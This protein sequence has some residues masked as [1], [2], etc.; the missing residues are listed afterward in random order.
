MR[1]RRALP[2][3]IV[4]VLMLTY[5]TSNYLFVEDLVK[6]DLGYISDEVWYVSAS[7]NML[8]EFWG[9]KPNAE[10]EGKTYATVVVWLPQYYNET[11]RWLVEVAGLQA[12][13]KDD[14]ASGS[15]RDGWDGGFAVLASKEILEE[16]ASNPNVEVYFGYP[17]PDHPGIIN[18]LNFEHPPLAK[19]VIAGV[20]LLS[21]NPIAWKIPSLILG[22]AII[23][24][25]YLV[26]RK[27]FGAIEGIIASVFIF[28]EQTVKAMSMVAMLD[29][30]LA[31]LTLL[32]LYLAVRFKNVWPS[33]LTVGL[34]AS[35]KMSGA[36]AIPALL[37]LSVKKGFLKRLP[38]IILAPIA[39]Y[40]LA[41]T[42]VILYFGGVW[43]WINNVRSAVG[44]YTTPRPSGPPTAT[45]IEFLFGGAS[46]PL[47]FNPPLSASPNIALTLLVIPLTVLL[48]PLAIKGVLKGAGAI[49]AWFWSTYF[50]YV[51]VYLAGNTTL[52]AF[53]AVQFMPIAAIIGSS[54]VTFILRHELLIKALRAYVEPFRRKPRLEAEFQP[55]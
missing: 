47:S 34:A 5:F 11:Y 33:T 14:Y 2:F 32:A 30:Y 46:F 52:Y 1:W 7:R 16:A 13:V 26:A 24:L 38:A 45:P 21:D 55:S 43:K 23:L 4:A 8:R 22:S 27:V 9:L 31:F 40:T 29:I 20:M 50:G 48:L 17:Y 25:A 35:A 36:F 3:A 37:A 44:W 28:T 51:A 53:Y 49:L 6:Q 15:L 41:S 12:I 18:Y 54:I 10:V 19:Y 39:V 42:P